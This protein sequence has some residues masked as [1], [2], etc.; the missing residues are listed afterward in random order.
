MSGFYAGDPITSVTAQRAG[1]DAVEA[2]RGDV[3]AAT[4]GS[5]WAGSYGPRLADWAGTNTITG[6]DSDPARPIFTGGTPPSPL[7]AEEANQRYG[8]PNVLN[9]TQPVTEAEA[10]SLAEGKRAEQ[11]RQSVIARRP[12]S[13]LTSGA[14][15]MAVSFAVGALDPVNLAAAMV[16]VIGEARMAGMLAGA[17]SAAGRAGIRAAVGG[18]QGAA[19]QALLE[20]L[21]YGLSQ[22]EHADWTM[23]E[24]IRNIAF[25]TILGGGLHVAGGAIADRVTGKYKN[26]ITQR[27][28]EAGPQARDAML[29]GSVAAVVEG[30][31]VDVAPILDL[32][33]APSYRAVT[34]DAAAGHYAAFTQAGQRI[35]ARPEVVS[36]DSLIVSNHDDGRINQAYIDAGGHQPRDR[37][38]PASQA[39][40]TELAANL[41]PERLR[42]APEA[43]SGAPIV[44]DTHVVESGNGRV[45]ALRRAYD[46]PALAHR[47][48][49]YR[50]FL[51]AQGYDLTGIERPVLIGRR[52]SALTPEEARGF[53][54]GANES[55]TLR[56]NAAEQAKADA[57]RAGRGIDQL[58]PG[59]LDG[60]A[61]D[62]FIGGF[63]AQLPAEERGAMIDSRGLLSPEGRSRIQNAILAHAY[64]DALPTATLEKLIAG[65]SPGSKQ[66]AGA[67]ADVAGE[68]GQLRAAAARGD[69]PAGLD[70]TP[71]IGQAVELAEQARR[72]GMTLADLLAQPDLLATRHP[73]TE[74][75]LRALYRDERLTQPVAEARISALL[76]R[77]VA[78]ALK[79]D[80]SPGL[81]GDAPLTAAEIL[82]TVSDQG[83]LERA[84]AALDRLANTPQVRPEDAAAIAEAGRM[85]Q[86]ALDIDAGRPPAI[87]ATGA[88]PKV[89]AKTSAEVSPAPPSSQSTP[90][91]AIE[92][93][94]LPPELQAAQAATDQAVAAVEGEIAAGRL[95]TAEGAE[96]RLAQQAMTLA[97]GDARAIEAAAACMI[98]KL[99]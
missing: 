98:G 21:G 95:T 9:F 2:S 53:A 33:S 82:R 89:N 97:E 10:A 80:P 1:L 6:L 16:P 77:Y 85:V 5:A 93:P 39:Q 76:E 69:I 99:I 44:A 70:I 42:P 50:A 4:A 15:R 17:G 13:L 63:M 75:V 67:L 43:A 26:P 23:G 68:W 11:L 62:G 46:T 45:L 92:T 59:A 3:L 28:E 79:V 37:A 96:M 32:P 55:T 72:T 29:R 36:L 35:E 71:A 8:I 40:I 38:N 18:A 19:G 91:P 30:R 57:A 56:M 86:V 7:T 25:G 84:G 66:I 47:A 20:P 48:A 27:I 88:A 51:E 87:A 60:R 65:E 58:R 12:D 83:Q 94:K 74:A 64:G 52:T 24:A 34:P 90:K 73:A 14:A 81:F 41:Q 22:R 49:A 54:R 61:N 78:E 31:P